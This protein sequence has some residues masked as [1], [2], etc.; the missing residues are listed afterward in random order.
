MRPTGAW[1]TLSDGAR[2]YYRVQG[3]PDGPWMAFFNGL[4]SDATL[5]AGVLPELAPVFRILTFDA[6]GQGRSDAPA[7]GPYTPG[8]LALDAWELF[9][10]LDIRR[11]WLVG[12]SNGSS[13]ALELLASRPG[14]FPG[15]VLTSAVTHTDF[16]MSLR[17]R[18][19]LQCLEQGGPGLQFDAAA[20]YLWGD[21][22]L[23]RRYQVLKSY[24]Q[25]TASSGELFLGSRHQI[26]GALQWDIRSRLEA[27]QDPVLFLAGA[28]DLL[29][30]VWK[31]LET[32][33][34]VPHARFEV[35]PGIGHAFPVEDP[36]AFAKRVLAFGNL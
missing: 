26:T 2:L 29:T 18:H 9:Q 34:A 35:I 6:R 11:P 14:A 33:R 32:A 15:A 30:P 16:S 10:R 8:Q 5:W 3:R 23:E 12:L 22:F 4:L 20:P 17:L 31:C 19:W 25:K 27:I 21:R 28:E 1:A 24:H 7:Q 13:V 36:K